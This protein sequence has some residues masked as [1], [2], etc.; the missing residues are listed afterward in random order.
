MWK[1]KI[2][3][4]GDGLISVNNFIG[5]QHWEFD[6]NAGTPQ[7]RAQV[8]R[9]REEYKKNRF[10]IKQSGDLLMRMQLTKENTCGPIL[11][12]VNVKDTEN[13][14]EEALITTMRKAINFYSSIQA[15]DG[16]WPA[17]SAGPLFFLQPLVMALYITGSLND[18]LGPEHQ[19]EIIRYLYNHQNEDGG[20]GLHIESH[21]TMF[22]S[23]L[24]YIALRI[25]GEGPEDGEDRAMAR[26]RKWILDHGGLEA[27]PSWGKFWVTVLGVY[28][29]SGCNPLPPEIWLLPKYAPIHP[30]KML[31]YCRLV[32]MPM[33]YLFGKR[34][35]GPITGLII[36]L[37][38]EMYNQP[39]DQIDWNN[40]RS[41][42]AKED[43]YYPH[44]LIQDMLWASLHHVAEPLLNCWPFSM[45][46]EK[47]LEVAIDHI[48]YEDENSGYLCIG[49]VEK[50]LCLIARW[51][52]DP[53]SEAYKLHLARIPDYFW[54]AEDGLKIQSLGSQLW[55][56]TLA[57]Q[58]IISCDLSEEY[59]PTLR[60]AHH[61]VKAS[62]VLENPSGN[63][64]A[65][66]RHISKGAWTFSMQDQG[67][68]VSDCTAE[69]L[70]AALLLSQMSPDLIG[71]KMEDERFYDAVDVILSL[72]SGNGGFPAWEP[73]R[74][75]RW[76]EKFNPT[77][78]FKDTLIEMEYVECTSSALQGL[79]LFR[80]LYPKHRRKEVDLCIS[81]A[82]RYI[83]KT[84]NPDGSWFGCWGICYTY[85]TLFSV[86][87]LTDCGKNY[88][89][90]PAL[91]KACKFLLSKQLPNG[92]WGESY[93]SSQNK[94]YTNLKGN[95]ANLVQTSW[96]LMSLIDAGQV[97]IDP[98]PVE[99]GI[100]LL[101]NSQMEDGDFP[102][103][104][105]TGV[106]MRN[107][108]LNYSSY[109]NIFLIWALGEYRRRV[110][111]HKSQILSST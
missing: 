49:S 22:G 71:E 63:F 88:R 62:Q 101:I 21:S 57:I 44:P 110:F 93:L 73:Q 97:E 89:N 65:M 34:F 59:G 70:K 75:Y 13:V 90:S 33:S 109:R 10:C 9:V 8:E 84:Q 26:G 46:R 11:A 67:W 2:A 40:A 76:L 61:F 103:Q 96:A 1:L 111:T 12:R 107:C 80:K 31:C 86:K 104:E 27:I 41:T 32:Y 74:A 68:Q 15:H 6:P 20:W 28:E 38:E 82:I 98:T 4:G 102:Q 42:V 45:L 52:E 14:T 53:N 3:E 48:R 64:K 87:G 19:K 56:A 30:G 18:V 105:I 51:V 78:I 91:R 36:S 25:L 94:V 24:S 92:G 23:A 29:W 37:R 54:L 55:D 99:R 95:R 50:V 106:F 35:V 77:E 17:E 108:T 58:A 81:K 69:G 16:H 60:K 79:A 7:E 83:E 72:Q 100:R 39:Y 47:A 5:R 66:H 43:L 85:G